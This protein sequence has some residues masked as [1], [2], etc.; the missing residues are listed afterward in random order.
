MPK[1]TR[2]D[3]MQKLTWT[4]P[5][6]N[7]LIVY[8]IFLVTHLVFAADDIAPG[9]ER[10]YQA[11]VADR[12]GLY[13]GGSETMHIVSHNGSLFASIGYWEDS[14]NIWYG[15]KDPSAAWAQVVRLDKPGGQWE[16]DLEMAPQYL[17]AEILKSITFTTDGNGELLKAPVN[18]LVA[19]AYTPRKKTVEITFFTRDDATGKWVTSTIY[20]GPKPAD[21]EDRSVRA[22]CMH[23]DKVTG[24]ER[25]FISIGK[26]GIFSGVYDAAVGK[27]RWDPHSESGPVEARPLAIV[28]AGGD[29]LFSAGRKIYRR[30]DGASPS[31]S[32]VRDMSD[33]YPEAASEAT[34]QPCGGIR[35]LSAIPNPSGKG[36]SLIFVM[37]ESG[38]SRGAIFRL[39]PTKDGRYKC[40][41]EVYLDELMSRYLSGNPVHAVL[42]GYNYFFPIV[43]PSTKET[44][45]LVGFESRI[46]GHRFPLCEAN[47]EGGFYAGGMYAIR[48]KNGTYRLKEINGRNTPSKPPLVAPRCFAISPFKEHAGDVIYFGGNDPNF[49]P[50]LNRAWIFSTSCENALR[51]DRVD[52]DKS[53]AGGK[54]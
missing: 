1:P 7:L 19:S 37:A 46:G 18:L 3:R 20:S 42:G 33:L 21:L 9:W 51:T 31:Y 26:L 28:K 35:G 22:I 15:G 30:N 12:N 47:K 16:V 52:Q 5:I 14:R 4:I 6:K 13:M 24:M 10:S 40:V 43:D 41:R 27:V 49:K 8:A 45:H 25:I 17:R 54:P 2:D 29:L 44:V 48:D 53:G 38:Q 11:G 36:E 23:R 39:D 50:S 34:F 32:V